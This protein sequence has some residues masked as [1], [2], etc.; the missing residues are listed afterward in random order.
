MLKKKKKKKKKERDYTLILQ[1]AW[2]FLVFI[3]PVTS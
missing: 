1:T 2:Q 3:Y